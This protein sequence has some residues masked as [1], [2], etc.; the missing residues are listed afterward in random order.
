MKRSKALQTKSIYQTLVSD[1][2]MLWAIA[3]KRSMTKKSII[4]TILIIII[5]TLCFWP[6]RY[7]TFY[8]LIFEIYGESTQGMIDADRAYSF[9][10]I[11]HLPVVLPL[12]LL[13]FD[14]I[15]K[16]LWV[17][18]RE[19]LKAN[20]IIAI[21]CVFFYILLEKLEILPIGT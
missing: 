6:I 14:T 11:R 1:I 12:I 8:I 13:M 15:S 20:V 9:F 10:P 19:R 21:G 16:R 17:A 7:G 2:R 18:D 4:R 3:K 5:S